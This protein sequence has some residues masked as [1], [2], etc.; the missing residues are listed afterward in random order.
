MK[1]TITKEQLLEW[2]M[3]HTTDPTTLLKKVLGESK[4]VGELAIILTIHN[5]V[6][7]FAIALPDG[8]MLIL[9]PLTID[10]LKKIEEMLMSYEPVW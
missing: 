9:N 7:A 2:G 5:N 3:N 6:Q 4:E 1:S 10:D 8:A